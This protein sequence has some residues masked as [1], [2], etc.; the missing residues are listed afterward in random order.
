MTNT[1]HSPSILIVD[2]SES[3]RRKIKKALDQGK[4]C[5]AFYEADNGIQGYKMLLNHKID[6]IICDV[7]MP[8]IDGFKL[9]SM[10]KNH[11]ELSDIP[12]IMLTSQGEQ[13][14]KNQGLE[15][16][17]SDYLIKPFDEI[18]LLARTRLHLKL[19]LLQDELQ[20]ANR[21]LTALSQTDALT[22]IYNRRHL[23]ETLQ[24]EI[25]RARRYATPLA[26]IITDLDDFKKLNDTYGHL[27][28]DRIL[29][30]CCKRIAGTIRATDVLARY[31]GEEFALVLPQIVIGDAAMVAEKIRSTV[32]ET[33]FPVEGQQLEVSLSCG[34]SCYIDGF[35]DTV[36]TLILEADR[37]L[38]R[39]K[40]EGKNR[41]I[42][43]EECMARME[44]T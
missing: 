27:V 32:A 23:M 24:N 44:T 14:K 1:N 11:P 43:S 36:D 33:P 35:S 37:A 19:K 8:Q 18:E 30:D 22:G 10:V 20:T 17:A 7:V 5:H 38:Y 41:T 16:G 12:M 42:V 4:L 34:V 13:G 39:A 26:F 40:R 28:G 6:L 2:D 15:K 25:E 3:I 9:L 21:R 31:G 29:V